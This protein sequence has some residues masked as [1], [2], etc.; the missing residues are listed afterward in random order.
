MI[1][2]IIHYCWFG[3]ANPSALELKCMASWEKYCPDYQIKLW[4]E[5]NF[6][7]NY[8]EFTREAYSL[9]KYAFVSDVARL[10]A[11]QQE[12]GVYLDTDMLIVG[13]LNSFL[14]HDLFTG[15]Y[16][17]GALN[18]AILG[19]KI[20]NQI[21]KELLDYYKKLEFD[22]HNPITIPEVFDHF[23]LKNQ[24]VKIYASDV[25]YPLPLDKKEEDY[26]TYLTKDSVAVHLWN[27][28][29]KN[30][31]SLLN[32]FKFIAALKF[33]ITNSI[34]YGEEYK[35]SNQRKL[36]FSKFWLKLKVYFY[37]LIF[38]RKER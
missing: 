24:S 19:S 9:G 33:Y 12:G 3:S 32:E 26:R 23:L 30:E 6:N 7:I 36:F 15:E 13:S 10:Y 20:G 34:K 1:P 16:K 27:H 25:F 8:S 37:S 14:S 5:D 18:A 28:S 11:L 31:M 4:N 2:K 29:W 22:F 38:K 21:V 35:K 17:K